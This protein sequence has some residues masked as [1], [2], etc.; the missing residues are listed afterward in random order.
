MKIH[1]RIT[2]KLLHST[3]LL[4][5]FGRKMP[6]PTFCEITT[7]LS[8]SYLYEN[9]LKCNITKD[10]FELLQKMLLMQNKCPTIQNLKTNI[11]RKP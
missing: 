2:E 10:E 6:S 9:Y 3:L 7:R 1:G 5:S 4:T 11:H 8:D